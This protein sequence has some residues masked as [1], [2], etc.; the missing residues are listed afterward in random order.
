MTAP[1][2]R[3]AYLVAAGALVVV[4]AIAVAFAGHTSATRLA[5]APADP[6]NLPVGPAVPALAAKGWLNSPPLTPADLTGKV[7]VYDFWT[8]SC[9][10]CVRTIPYVRSWFNRYQPDG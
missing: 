3:R 7:V 6:N 5:G 2:H 8:Y 1:G 4:S 9:V 10:N